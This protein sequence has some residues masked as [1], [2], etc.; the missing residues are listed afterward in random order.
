MDDRRG[1]KVFGRILRG[2]GAGILGPAGRPLEVNLSSW[3]PRGV[4]T[5][6]GA[7]PGAELLC[8]LLLSGCGG[9]AK[10]YSY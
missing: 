7:V 5:S 6:C 10:A 4:G 8:L 2:E 1:D 9:V 3:F